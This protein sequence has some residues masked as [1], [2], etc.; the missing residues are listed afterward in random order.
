MIVDDALVEAARQLLLARFG[1]RA[2]AASAV[3]TLEGSLFTSVSVDCVNPGS[4]VEPET[5]AL[6]EAFKKGERISAVAT[7]IR[8]VDGGPVLSSTPAGPTID[9]LCL[10]A[11]RM[12]FDADQQIAILIGQSLIGAKQW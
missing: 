11:A 10:A 7:M 2:D 12:V 5:G 8:R 6:A 4:S 1:T 9:R 3:Y